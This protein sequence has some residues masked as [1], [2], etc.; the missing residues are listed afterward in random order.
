MKKYD[1]TK[2][3][4][5]IE[6]VHKLAASWEDCKVIEY[7]QKLADERLRIYTDREIEIAKAVK[8]LHPGFGYVFQGKKM[9]IVLVSVSKPRQNDTAPC[10]WS[11]VGPFDL[12]SKTDYA[13]DYRDS[14]IDI[15][16]AIGQGNQS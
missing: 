15:D 12:A 10:G 2:T 5:F 16:E 8:V 9:G 14:L 3:E 11:F 7:V 4:D 6:V 13:D 1:C